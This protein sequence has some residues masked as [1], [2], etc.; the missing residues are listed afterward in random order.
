[1]GYGGRAPE[2]RQLGANEALTAWQELDDTSA[3]VLLLWLAAEEVTE[4]LRSQAMKEGRGGK[5]FASGSL[6]AG[7]L[8]HIPAGM[9]DIFYMTYPA[10]LPG[11]NKNRLMALQRWL[12]VRG[13]PATNLDIQ[14]R[15]YFLGWMLPDAIK[16]MRGEFYRDYFLETFDMMTDQDAAIAVFPRLSF[17]P[18]QRY[19]S[20]GC[21]IVQLSGDENPELVTVSNWVIN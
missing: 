9:R 19:A 16:H 15:M 20:K 14:S 10:S 1:V 11:E 6:L 12:K 4:V 5:L 18:G 8:D 3:P 2:N 13:I 21:Y 17:G 7:K